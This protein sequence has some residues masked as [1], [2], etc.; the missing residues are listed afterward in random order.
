MRI[1]SFLVFLLFGLELGGIFGCGMIIFEIVICR[2]RMKYR[3]ASRVLIDMALTLSPRA[4][5]SSFGLDTSSIHF[6]SH[7]QQ[8][9]RYTMYEGLDLNILLIVSYDR[10][11]YKRRRHL[12]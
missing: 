3:M 4:V 7:M 9:Q 11:V 8:C 10:D 12:P 6:L 2:W 5:T 1:F